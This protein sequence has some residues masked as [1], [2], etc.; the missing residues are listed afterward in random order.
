[1]HA[2]IKSVAIGFGKRRRSE[3][4]IVALYRQLRGFRFH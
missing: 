4:S 2:R 1:M 3:R